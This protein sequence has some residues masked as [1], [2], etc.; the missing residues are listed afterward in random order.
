MTRSTSHIFPEKWCKAVG[1][2]PATYNSVINKTALAARTNRHIGG[3]A[4]SGYLPAIEKASGIGAER[5]DGIL[6]SHCIEP[7]HLRTDRFWEFYAAR[8]EA[9]LQRRIEAQFFRET[10]T[11]FRFGCR[12]HPTS[13]GLQTPA[14]V[15]IDALQPNHKTRRIKYR[16]E[17]EQTRRR[18]KGLMCCRLFPLLAIND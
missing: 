17:P 2:E 15:G 6:R 5:M 11:V 1:I 12:A 3:Y 8:A 18:V 10:L 9:L 7:E 4:P 16:I 14:P 13:A